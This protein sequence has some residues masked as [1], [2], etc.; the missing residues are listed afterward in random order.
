[1]RPALTA[2]PRPL[3]C[4]PWPPVSDLILS[5]QMFH[6][7]VLDMAETGTE[8]E[9]TLKD[10]YSFQSAKINPTFVKLDKPFLF[11]VFNQE[12]EIISFMGKIENPAQN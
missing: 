9:A 12:S 2:Y 5:P 11:C 3:S 7:V 1:M 4:P 10:K 6:N 8:A